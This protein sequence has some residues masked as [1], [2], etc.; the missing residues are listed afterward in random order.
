MEEFITL[1]TFALAGPPAKTATAND[2]QEFFAAV[3]LLEEL[4]PEALTLSLQDG[5]PERFIE[6][7]QPID[8]F[9]LEAPRAVQSDSSSHLHGWASNWIRN[10]CLSR[11]KL[12]IIPRY[13]SVRIVR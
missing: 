13:H 11:W 12:A 7:L 8:E 5:N 9:A 10:H 1:P 4:E 2:A 3:I 6:I